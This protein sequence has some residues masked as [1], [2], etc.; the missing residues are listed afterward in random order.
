MTTYS[1]E[2]EKVCSEELQPVRLVTL[3]ET[4]VQY[5]EVSDQWF[6][7]EGKAQAE[8]L[9]PS[10][11]HPSLPPSLSHPCQLAPLPVAPIGPWEGDGE[12]RDDPTLVLLV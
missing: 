7:Q 11:F 9:P 12:R 1:S 6:I 10:L 2:V 5:K 4:L 8:C 3:R